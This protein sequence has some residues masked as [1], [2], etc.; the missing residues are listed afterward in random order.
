MSNNK[1][2]MSK[3]IVGVMILLIISVKFLTILISKREKIKKIIM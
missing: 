3:R 1:K 2:K